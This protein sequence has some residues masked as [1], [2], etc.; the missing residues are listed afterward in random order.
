MKTFIQDNLFLAFIAIA[1]AVLFALLFAVPAYSQPEPMYVTNTTIWH[2]AAEAASKPPQLPPNVK[3]DLVKLFS[4]ILDDISLTGISS[5]GFMAWVA[6]R[7]LRKGIPDAMQDGILG[8]VLKHAALEINPQ[9]AG[10]TN[11][12]Q[13]TNKNEK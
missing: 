13:P 5:A 1:W 7:L 11:D 9:V 3:A 4:D 10:K 8:T 6:A 2:P 12:S